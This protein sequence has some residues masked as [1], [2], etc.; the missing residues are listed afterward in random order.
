MTTDLPE[1][2]A[3]FPFDAEINRTGAEPLDALPRPAALTPHAVASLAN[4]GHVVLDVRP[5]AAFGAGHVPGAVN[6]GLGGQ[7]ASWAGSLITL[8]TPIVIVAET[9]GQVDE[10]LVRL[11]RVGHETVRGY[12]R[13]GMDAWRAH[14]MEEA[15]VPQ[16][17]QG[18][19][20]M[21]DEEPALRCRLA[22][23]PEYARHA[24]RAASAPLS[25]PSRQPRRPRTRTPPRLPLRGGYRS[26]AATIIPNASSSTLFTSKAEPSLGLRRLPRGEADTTIWIKSEYRPM[27]EGEN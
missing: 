17:R 5:A 14:H 6:V 24:P 16:V 7:F 2:P 25:P 11:A 12:L 4:Q 15:T 3:Y 19:A 20:P 13:G 23:P 1:Q 9:G 18:A 21:L 8:R 27:N 22:P 26:S 10:A